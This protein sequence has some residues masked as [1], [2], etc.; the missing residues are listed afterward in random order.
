MDRR[1]EPA[2]GRRDEPGSDEQLTDEQRAEIARQRDL[3]I[4]A[5]LEEER[6]TA[7]APIDPEG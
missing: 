4:A 2:S 6:K 1:D 5:D 3:A 7:M